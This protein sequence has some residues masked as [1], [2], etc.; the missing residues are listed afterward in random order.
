MRSHPIFEA[1]N[2]PNLATSLNNLAHLYHTQGRLG[3]AERDHK[4][5][6][7]L[8][9]KALPEGHP[10][11]AQSLNNL[12]ALYHTQGRLGDAERDHK[13]ALALRRR[14]CLRTILTLPSASTTSRACI[15]PKVATPTP[16]PTSSERWRWGR[17]RSPRAILTMR[18]PQQ[19]RQPVSNSRSLRRR[20]ARLWLA[21]AMREKALPEGHR[22]IAQSLNNLLVCIELK[23][24]TPSRVP[25]QASAGDGG[26]NVPRGPS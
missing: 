25:L 12:A 23:V 20:R 10:D 1:L 17:R 3:D 21:L 22:S 24:A 9:E 4:R 11:I 5:A 16:S 7:A 18:T 8:R 2:H 14:R 6:L 19:P 15:R 13:R 26:E